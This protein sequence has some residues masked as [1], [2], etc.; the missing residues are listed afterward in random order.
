MV[1]DPK[2]SARTKVVALWIAY[3]LERDSDYAQEAFAL[4]EESV[5]RLFQ[6]VQ[7]SQD[8]DRRDE[9]RV[10]LLLPDLARRSLTALISSTSSPGRS[11]LS[12]KCFPRCS[13]GSRV[14]GG[15]KA[16]SLL[17]LVAPKELATE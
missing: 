16:L 2:N 8:P 7:W 13:T 12:S 5:V 11:A 17:E 9:E 10:R 15:G 4:M 3:D 6:T 14:G 1:I